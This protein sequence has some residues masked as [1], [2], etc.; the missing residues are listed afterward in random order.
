MILPPHNRGDLTAAQWKRIAPLLPTQ[1]PAVGR[2]NNDYQTI[3]N[4][5]LWVLLSRCSV[6][7]Y[8]RRALWSVGLLSQ[9]AFTEL[10]KQGIWRPPVPETTTAS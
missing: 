5:I 9:D 7:G 8:P 6:A 1:K 4:G 2:P 3:I 10:R